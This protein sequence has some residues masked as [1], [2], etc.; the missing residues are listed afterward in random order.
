VQPHWSALRFDGDR[1]VLLAGPRGHVTRDLAV[2]L[3]P[4]A[5]LAR[6]AFNRLDDVGVLAP[7]QGDEILIGRL[8]RNEREV[9]WLRELLGVWRAPSGGGRP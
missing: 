8:P 3:K 7:G 9:C 5:C 1:I 2:V 4:S 6:H